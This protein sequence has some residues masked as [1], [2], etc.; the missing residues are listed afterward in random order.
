MRLRPPRLGP[1]VTAA[2]LEA[3]AE[4]DRARVRAE[5]RDRIDIA[6]EVGVDFEAVLR[7][8]AHTD[9]DAVR[10]ALDQ[11]GAPA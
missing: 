11:A 2:Q 4:R 5:L 6:R 10:Y 9:P 8:V 1:V 7:A 3:D